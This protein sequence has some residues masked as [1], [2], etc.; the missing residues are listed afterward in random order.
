MALT[1]DELQAYCGAALKNAR[2]LID[3]S[4]LLLKH[5]CYARTYFLSVAAIE[6]TGKAVMAFMGQGRNLADPAVEAK[7]RANLENHPAKI[8]NAFVP[9]MLAHEQNPTA[10]RAALERL[11]EYVTA[12]R[13]G[14]EPSMYVDLVPSGTPMKRPAERV[15]PEVATDCVALVAKCWTIAAA[16]LATKTPSESTSEQDRFFVLSQ[17]KVRQI[18]ET[19]DFWWYYLSCVE[20]GNWDIAGAAAAYLSEYAGKKTPFKRS[21]PPLS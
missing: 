20:S 1:V 9:W 11:L 19:E 6:E 7:L 5:E 17:H 10:F 16:Y 4:Q 12:L 21:E 13:R 15:R 8:L 14:R 18:L 2:E 3:E